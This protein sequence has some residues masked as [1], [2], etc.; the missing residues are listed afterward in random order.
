MAEPA[1]LLPEEVARL[2]EQ[3]AGITLSADDAAAV[4]ALL[5]ALAADMQAFRQ[6]D[7]GAAEP[8]AVYR[9]REAE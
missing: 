1:L 3:A 9:A 2:A 4:S 7:V 5:A 8:A 6:F